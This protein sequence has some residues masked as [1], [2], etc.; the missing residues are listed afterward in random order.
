MADR[1]PD[2]IG[3]IG[4]RGPD[5]SRGRLTGW[6]NYPLVRD[7]AKRALMVKPNIQ[8]VSGGAP[9]GV[10]SMI[11]HACLRELGFCDADHIRVDPTSVDCQRPH[12]HEFKAAWRNPD[13]SQNKRAGFERND[14]LVRHV[15][16]LL[17][18]YAPGELTPGTTHAIERARAHSV[19]V[20][21]YQEGIWR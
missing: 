10:D 16:L 11:R 3:V 20:M 4:S 8:I 19:P 7:I 2:V 13:G 5:A 17:A 18:L 15:G 12:F 21:V 14:L 6:T 1:L 9:S